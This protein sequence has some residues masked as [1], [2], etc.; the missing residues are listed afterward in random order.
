MPAILHYKEAKKN[1]K[2][3]FI[4]CVNYC[5]M[6]DSIE[7]ERYKKIQ[8]KFNLPQLH[9]LRNTFKFELED[10]EKLIDDIRT[11]ISDRLFGFTE[12]ILEPIIGGSESFC[13][14]FEQDMISN[15]ERQKLF[16]LY[17]KIQVLK[18]ENNLLIVKPDDNTTA[19]WI[20]RTW[21]LWNNELET[22]LGA[23]CKKLSIAWKDLKIKDEK[24]HYT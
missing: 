11:E 8:E 24:T 22:E 7:F 23:L 19:E 18:W 15:A 21:N 9:D 1:A 12:K 3:A 10:S 14:M 17:K 6:K 16:D 5:S 2:L 13:C 20:N 4:V